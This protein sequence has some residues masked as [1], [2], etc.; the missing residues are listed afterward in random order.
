METDWRCG[1]PTRTETVGHLVSFLK[2]DLVICF[3]KASQ[4]LAETLN[5][6]VLIRNN[7]NITRH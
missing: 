1:F 6:F 2:K 4:F 5:V 7:A 3:L